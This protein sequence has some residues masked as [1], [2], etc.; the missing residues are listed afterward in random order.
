MLRILL[1]IHYMSYLETIIFPTSLTL[2][3]KPNSLY[4]FVTEF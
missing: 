1:Y 4:L 3:F 2:H